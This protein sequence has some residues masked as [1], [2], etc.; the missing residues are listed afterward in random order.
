MHDD[1]AD[2]ADHRESTSVH[3]APASV[4]SDTPSPITSTSRIAH[5]S[6]VPAQTMFGSEGATATAPMACAVILSKTG[7][8]VFP[9]STDF[10]TPP[11]AEAR[12]QTRT[13]PGTPV[14][15]EIH[16][17]RRVPSSESGTDC[18]S[19][20]GLAFKTNDHW[21]WLALKSSNK[22]QFSISLESAHVSDPGPWDVAQIFGLG[23]GRRIE[24]VVHTIGHEFGVGVESTLFSA[25]APESG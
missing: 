18:R 12:Y 19:A 9:S 22:G 16:R 20:Q 15:A 2:A 10:H 14:I 21:G 4:D 13:S 7:T 23:H 17:P 3:V 1:A 5:A 25:S 11:E 6:P 24:L 8:N